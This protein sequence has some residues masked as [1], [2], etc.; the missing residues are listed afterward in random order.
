MNDRVCDNVLTFCLYL[1]SISGGMISVL[2]I[3]LFVKTNA[4]RN[5]FAK[6]LE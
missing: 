1:L 3:G 5:F 6:L 4:L 2:H